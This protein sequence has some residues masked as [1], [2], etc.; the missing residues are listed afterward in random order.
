MCSSDLGL[1]DDIQ[2]Q[3]VKEVKVGKD[4]VVTVTFQDL[5]HDEANGDTIVYTPSFENGAVKW[6]CKQNTTLDDKWRPA[7]CRGQ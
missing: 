5:G 2:S 7:N 3:Y 4:G 6:D 1:E